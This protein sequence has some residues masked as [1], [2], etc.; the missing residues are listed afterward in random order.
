MIK[1]KLIFWPLLAV[2]IGILIFGFL[3]QGQKEE[4]TKGL[5]EEIELASKKSKAKMKAQK[6]KWDIDAVKALDIIDVYNLLLKRSPFFRVG[7]DAKPKK[8][9]LVPVK[10]E[11]KKSILKYKGKA[12]MGS[13]VMVVIEDEGTGKSYFVQ[14]GDMV[15][16]FLVERIDEKEIALRK[17]GGEEIILSAVKKEKEEEE[18][19]EKKEEDKEEEGKKE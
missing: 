1:E 18:N 12:I 14:E 16:D 6:D 8:V 7:D 19:E 5:L 9:E 13:K 11:P 10:E 2:F 4:A 15:G 3:S 17:K